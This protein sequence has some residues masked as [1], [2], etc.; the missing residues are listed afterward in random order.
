MPCVIFG[1]YSWLDWNV[2]G[3]AVTDCVG[4]LFIGGL[5]GLVPLLLCRHEVA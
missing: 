5:L 3:T 1:A 2:N 4:N